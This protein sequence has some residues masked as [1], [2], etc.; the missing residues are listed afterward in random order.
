MTRAVA[1]PVV[2]ALVDSGPFGYSR[3]PLYIGNVLMWAGV[4][5]LTGR[6]WVAA[7]MIAALLPYYGAIVRWEEGR[8]DAELGDAYRAYRARVP[9]WLLGPGATVPQRGEWR[10]AARSERSTWLAALVVTAAVLARGLFLPL[11]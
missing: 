6:A 4:G 10:E 7:G 9:R 1:L 8:L 5:L 2:G 3:N 11:S